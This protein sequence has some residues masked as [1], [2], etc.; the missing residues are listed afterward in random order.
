M[1]SQP[2]TTFTAFRP[3]P[4]L[5]ELDLAHGEISVSVDDREHA[6]I[7]LTPLRHADPDAAKLINQATADQRGQHWTVTVPSPA[8]TVHHRNGGLVVSQ[9]MGTVTGT[10][11]GINIDHSGRV[12][13]GTAGRTSVRGGKI[14]ADIR[15]PRG[16]S[17][18]VNTV[19]ANLATTGL[20]NTVRFRSTSGSLTTAAVRALDADTVSGTVT[21]GQAEK[22]RVSTT[23]GTIR[24]AST[25]ITA[26]DTMSGA[27]ELTL[28]GGHADAASTSGNVTVHATEPSTVEVETMSGHISLSA[29]AGV[30]LRERTHTMSGRIT[31]NL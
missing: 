22:A 12:T 13:T 21:A 25:G 5:L 7:T 10:V 6:E 18:R 4:V 20:L 11:V 31:R 3:G 24:L 15:L 19:S 23:S 17:V 9:V 27:I 30:S 28:H 14:R 2:N 26:V 29:A 16:S 1:P 8:E